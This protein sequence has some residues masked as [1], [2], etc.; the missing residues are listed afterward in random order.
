MSDLF[1]YLHFIFFSC[2][3]IRSIFCLVTSVSARV[4]LW[5]KKSFQPIAAVWYNFWI[6]TIQN[7]FSISNE[8]NSNLL[9]QSVFL[10]LNP[11]ILMPP[12]GFVWNSITLLEIYFNRIANMRLKYCGW[13]AAIVMEIFYYYYNNKL[14]I[15]LVPN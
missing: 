1:D 12:K 11:K 3:F 4:E 10:M 15:M 14:V 6:K 8:K 13:K 9:N 2:K 7:F 5:Q